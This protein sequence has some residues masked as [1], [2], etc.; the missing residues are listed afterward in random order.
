LKE[1]DKRSSRKGFSQLRWKELR[2]EPTLLQGALILEVEKDCVERID[3]YTIDIP[4]DINVLWFI[5][6]GY[7]AAAYKNTVTTRLAQEPQR[8]LECC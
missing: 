7:K 8:C 5:L 2:T 4:R 1:F 3:D 6:C